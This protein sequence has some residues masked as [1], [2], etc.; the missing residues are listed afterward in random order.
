MRVHTRAEEGADGTGLRHGVFSYGVVGIRADTPGVD[1]Q[2]AVGD[3]LSAFV[4]HGGEYA[5][6][7]RDEN[8][9]PAY[10]GYGRDEE[11]VRECG[12]DKGEGCEGS[13]LGI[14]STKN[15]NPSVTASARYTY[16]VLLLPF[17]KGETDWANKVLSRQAGIQPTIYT[18]PKEPRSKSHLPE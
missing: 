13:C 12:R 14:I 16:G 6:A 4:Y 3:G 11:I 18:R 10:G 7:D 8:K 9:E 5:E 2:G 1:I 17:V 15:F